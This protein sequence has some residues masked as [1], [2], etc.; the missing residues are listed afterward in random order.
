M[1]TE[2]VRIDALSDKA[3]ADLA[4]A[5]EIIKHFVCSNEIADVFGRAK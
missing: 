5:A 3:S 4:R 2:I 1:I